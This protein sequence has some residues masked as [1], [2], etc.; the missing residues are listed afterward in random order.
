MGK[1][2]TW[3]SLLDMREARYGFNSC[4]FNKYVYLCGSCYGDSNLIEAFSPQTDI[5]QLQLLCIFI[6]TV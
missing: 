1:T 4:L 6:R 2:L 5:F 3:K